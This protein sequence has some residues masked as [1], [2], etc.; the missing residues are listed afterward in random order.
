[1]TVLARLENTVV[2]IEYLPG[3][4][5]PVILGGDQ[6]HLTA[7]GFSEFR[8]YSYSSKPPIDSGY[9]EYETGRWR[10][11]LCS[12]WN[13]RLQ[14]EAQLTKLTL[15]KTPR[16]RGVLVSELAWPRKSYDGSRIIVVLAQPYELALVRSGEPERVYAETLGP[17]GLS[18]QEEQTRFNA[19]VPQLMT[20]GWDKDMDGRLSK[21]IPLADLT[22]ELETGTPAWL[23]EAIAQ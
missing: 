14:E 18:L 22:L 11:Y 19:I 17:L 10:K 20:E 12:T 2:Q 8:L 16:Y 3:Y 23:L 7:H 15:F 4:K 1:M 13:K 21:D 5:K 9:E 6:Q